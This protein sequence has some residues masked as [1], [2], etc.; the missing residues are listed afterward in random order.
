[1][2]TCIRLALASFPRW[3]KERYGTE[4]AQLTEDVLADEA[5]NRLRVLSDLTAGSI[6]AW[7]HYRRPQNLQRLAGGSPWGTVP[8]G[9]HRDLFGN[10]GLSPRSRQDL[11]PGEVVLSVFDGWRGSPILSNLPVVCGSTLITW[12]LMGAFNVSGRSWTVQIRV[13]VLVNFAL[14]VTSAIVR[15]VT[16]SGTVSI[17]V[18][19]E[20]LAIFRMRPLTNRTAELV[21]RMPAAPPTV[22]K[23]GTSRIK[24]DLGG[25]A[26]WLRTKSLPLIRWMT[27][28]PSVVSDRP[29]SV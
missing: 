23:T 9:G 8:D 6:M 7:A 1:M 16:K 13:D 11:E 5:S 21:R 4:T 29:N 19:T 28:I 22:V 18:T 14:F 25:R 17:A 24:V 10:R 12:L 20:G 26:F 2:N 15:H 27:V 3:W